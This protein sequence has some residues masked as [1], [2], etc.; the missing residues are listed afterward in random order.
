MVF[1][2]VDYPDL[3]EAFVNNFESIWVTG[4]DGRYE[5]LL[6]E[7]TNGTDDIPLVYDSMALTHAEVK[8]LKDAIRAA[9]PEV[10]SVDFRQM[11]QQN[12]VCAR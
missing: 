10:D 9:C 1:E 5:T 7:I 6:D 12:K 4:L 8:A 3:V 2:A 11:P